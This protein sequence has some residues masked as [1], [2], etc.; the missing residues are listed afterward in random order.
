MH[1]W[2]F[3]TSIIK[4]LGVSGTEIVSEGD[5]DDISESREW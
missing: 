1:K 3:V 2:S 5:W 4:V